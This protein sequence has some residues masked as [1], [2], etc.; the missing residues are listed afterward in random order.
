MQIMITH[1]LGVGLWKSSGTVR[2]RT[3]FRRTGEQ[4]T[5]SLQ[6]HCLD[7]PRCTRKS[8]QKYRS[9]SQVLS[10]SVTRM[11][12][13]LATRTLVEMNAFEMFST[14]GYR[15]CCTRP[16]ERFRQDHLVQ[17]RRH[18]RL[19]ANPC[20]LVSQIFK[21]WTNAVPLRLRHRSLQRWKIPKPVSPP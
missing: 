6:G 5:A 12:N 4:T 16:R 9:L 18:S 20:S 14:I 1:G 17:E 3:R 8:R 21:T 7:D 11:E 13:A 15:A 19:S 10:N 2:L